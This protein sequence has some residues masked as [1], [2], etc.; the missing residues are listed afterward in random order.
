MNRFITLCLL[1][2][3]ACAA[4]GPHQI[5]GRAPLISISSLNLVGNRLSADFDVRNPNDESMT[6]DAVEIRMSLQ[7]TEVSR[8][9]EGL[10]IGISPQGTEEVHVESLPDAFARNLLKSL[11]S[12]DVISLPY[13]LEGRVHTQERGY[14]EF[15]HQG[16]LY[17]VPGRPGRFRGAGA[18]G[19]E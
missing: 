3:F 6:I 19:L 11:E 7:D 18:Q 13:E 4:C 12:G 2:A 10:Q 15:S 14:L 16:H 5:R 9:N 17:P 1:I 8:N